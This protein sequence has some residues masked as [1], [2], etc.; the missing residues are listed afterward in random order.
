VCNK[1]GGIYTVLSSK[2]VQAITTFG[3]AN[4]LAIGPWTGTQPDTFAPAV[5][6]SWLSPV[7]S[8][9]RDQGYT[10]HFG[11]WLIDG[12]PQVVLIDWQPLVAR[13]ADLK[14]EL[15]EYAKLDTLNT[16]FY[17]ID[18]PLLWSQAVAILVQALAATR[19]EQ[20]TLFHGHEWWTSG[21]ILRLQQAAEQGGPRVATVFTTH[22][23]VLGRALSS[24]GVDIYATLSTTN[25]DQAAADCNVTTK[26][27]LE[28]LAAQHATTFTTVSRI[29]GREATQYLGRTPTTYT[30][31]G[32]DRALFPNYDELTLERA[33]MRQQ[34]NDFLEAYLFPSHQ[35]DL[36]RAQLQF[37]MGR[38]EH[39]NKGYDTYIQALGRLNTHLKHEHDPRPVVAFL[40]I[41]GGHQGLAPETQQ[42][43]QLHAQLRQLLNQAG[44]SQHHRS[45]RHMWDVGHARCDDTLA[46][47]PKLTRDRAVA[48]VQR[49]AT[50]AAVPVS[51]LTLS[52]PEESIITEATNAGLFN[53]A[54][55]PV[56]LIWIPCYLDGFDPL[57]GTPLYNL[58]MGC[59]LG[60]FPSVY[61]PWGYTPME[62]M[63]HGAPSI[64]SDLA[65]FGIALDH[66]PNAATNPG[67]TI[68]RRDGVSQEDAVATL[69][70][71]LQQS[72]Q[73]DART[74]TDQRIAAYQAMKSFDWS[75]LYA[76]YHTAYDHA[77]RTVSPA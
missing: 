21:A 74:Y 31:N 25:P 36:D 19:G 34:L 10:I 57:F 23:T 61:E 66:L 75:E 3:H 50:T 6:P 28:R 11:S 2:A 73:T 76:A 22:A 30:E 64:T 53:R 18:Q 14:R 67:F 65:G 49:H 42:H 17:D 70:T 52:Y 32:L 56:K 44:I 40:F 63:I 1:I 38:Y 68:L 20:P 16:D 72:L 48:L 13:N 27:Q 37:T 29:T 33:R 39:H 7:L 26:H 77:L 41:P 45:Y 12:S 47:L 5:E 24:R 4:Y 58:V 8:Q 54:E 35:I 69:A 15:W 59:D 51:P 9:L 60:V 55:D 62:G 46:L 71:L 43:L